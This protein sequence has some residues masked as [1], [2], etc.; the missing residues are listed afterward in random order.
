[1]VQAACAIIKRGKGLRGFDRYLPCPEPGM[2]LFLQNN[3]RKRYDTLLL[4]TS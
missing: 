2:V 1:M 3:R 4:I